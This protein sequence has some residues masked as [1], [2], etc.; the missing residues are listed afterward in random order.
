M[1]KFL[2]SLSIV[3]GLLMALLPLALEFEWIDQRPSFFYQTLILLFFSTAIIYRYLHKVKNP[4][5][6]TQLYLLL[7]VVKL[8]AYMGYNLF[9]VLEDK[10]GANYNVVFFLIVYLVFTLL[11]IVFLYRQ[12]NSKNQP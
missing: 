9:I 4:S 1:L 2:I 12:I 6:F 5:L 7:M 8:I 11:E 10:R 3:S